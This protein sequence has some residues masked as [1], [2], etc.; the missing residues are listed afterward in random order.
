M[1][2]LTAKEAR[3]ITASK[4]IV[5][6]VALSICFDR[7]KHSAQRGYSSTMIAEREIPNFSINQF[8]LTNKLKELG[9]EAFVVNHFEEPKKLI[10]NWLN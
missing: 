4:R 2:I 7:I 3:E 9:Y 1:E 8:N 6:D 10:I 5:D